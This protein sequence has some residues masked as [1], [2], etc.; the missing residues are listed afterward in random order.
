MKINL[1]FLPEKPYG[2]CEVLVFH[3]NKNGE[4]IHATNV[5]FCAI[6]GMFNTYERTEIDDTD[7]EFNKNIVAWAY[8]DDVNEELNYEIQ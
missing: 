8:M 7:Y 5:H 6:F 2:D 1:H 3:T 4:I